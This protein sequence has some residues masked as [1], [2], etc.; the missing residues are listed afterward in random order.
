LAGATAGP[1]RE[2]SRRELEVLELIAEGLTN[3]AIADR[4]VISGHT[5]HRHVSSILRKL[6]V[7]TRSAAAAL[8]AQH[9]LGPKPSAR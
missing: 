2:L 3:Q 7:P 5:V 9:G 6:E 4:L 1:L 8:A